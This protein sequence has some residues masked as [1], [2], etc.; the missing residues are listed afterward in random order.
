MSHLL[1]KLRASFFLL[2]LVVGVTNASA[3]TPIKKLG[4]KPAEK[5]GPQPGEMYREF[6]KHNGGNRDWR[7]TDHQAVKKFERAADHLP[8]S[9]LELVI[10]DLQH[11]VRA[12]MLLDR[13]GGHRGTIN[14]RVRLNE[15]DWILIPE[16]ETVPKGIRPE[17][18]MYQDNPIVVVPL[19][20]LKEGVNIFEGD[21]DEQGGFGWGQWGLYSMVVRVYYDPEKKANGN[22]IQGRITAPAFGD[23]FDESPTIQVSADAEMGVT[24]IDVLASYDG[25]DEDGDGV[26]DGYHESHFQ[27]ANGQANEIRNHVGTLWRKPYR[28]KW[29]TRWVPDQRCESIKLLARIQDSRGYWLVTEP[30][31]QL[32]LRRS[33]DSVK[34]YR[35]I[36]VPENFSV[37]VDETKSCRFV[38]PDSDPIMSASEAALHLRTW[39]GWDGHHEPI[40]INDHEMPVD[41]KNHFYDY[42]V[43]E[44]P[45]EKLRSGENTFTMH[46]KTEHHMLEVLW[47]GP[48][49]VVRMPKP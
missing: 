48:A 26:F 46:S 25:F 24:R 23:T 4:E 41:G 2:V 18:L 17:Q 38:I 31:E 10:E 22:R 29:N 20:H 8:N 12:E 16:I 43:L 27:L 5:L 13:W 35:A 21:C 7:V 39:H 32:S 40:K 49:I 14:K 9:K 37:R 36:D 28:M 3:Q 11:A 47:P 19:S 15:N 45:A 30:V 6:A 1:L 44:F 34:L 42:D 33:A